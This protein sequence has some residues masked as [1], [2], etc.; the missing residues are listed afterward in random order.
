MDIVKLFNSI[1]EDKPIVSTEVLEINKAYKILSLKDMD[2]RYGRSILVELNNCKI[3]LPKR[4]SEKVDKTLIDEIN[5]LGNFSVTITS[6]KTYGRHHQKTPVLE[7]KQ[8]EKGNFFLNNLIKISKKY[9]T[10][11]TYFILLQT[12]QATTCSRMNWK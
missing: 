9:K 3:F 10:L 7:M 5:R 8:L 11:I 4:Y 12:K 6:F 1:V 2:T